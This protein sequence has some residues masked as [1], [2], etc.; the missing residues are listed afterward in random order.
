ME[1]ALNEDRRL[2]RDTVR[3][4]IE[5]E[6]G[7]DARRK[8]VAGADGFSRDT[9]RRFADMGW[10]GVPVPEDHGGFGGTLMDVC[11]VMEAFGRGLVAEPFLPTCVLGAG[12]VTA[13]GDEAKA[14]TLL[15]RI[16][17]GD[18]L[19][20]VAMGEPG[21]RYDI[22]R[23][24]TRAERTSSGWRLTGDKAVVLGAGT[25][26]RIVVPALTGEA[27]NLFLVDRTVP[28]MAVRAYAT[29]DGLRAAELALA[30]VEV[31]ADAVIGEVGQG[32]GPLEE[33][34][35]RARIALAAEAAGAMAALVALTGDYLRQREQFGGPIARFQVLQHHLVDMYMEQELAWS[36]V[37][38]AAAD[39]EASSPAER[40]MLAS[41]AKARAGK[42]GTIVGQTAIQ[43]HG[44]MGMTEEMAAGH[45]FKRLALIDATLGNQAWHN[46]RY[47]GLRYGG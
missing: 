30:G 22:G 9:W 3:Q 34:A 5:R 47:A 16:V 21:S 24:E 46:R 41:A 45:Y 10:L 7:F 11:V 32:L 6:Y 39:F 14:A 27:V 37:L 8:A 2:L 13:S 40:A 19:M 18:L 42:A 12:V 38:R 20:A 33:T 17:A 44:G 23:I 43:L 26:D 28:G 29:G 25:A 31:G 36:L 1:I 35:D 15:P 4:Y